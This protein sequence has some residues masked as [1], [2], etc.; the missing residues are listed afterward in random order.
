MTDFTKIDAIESEIRVVDEERG[1]LL[2]ALVLEKK[3]CAGQ[4]VAEWK[5]WGKG[6]PICLEGNQLEKVWRCIPGEDLTDKEED[7]LRKS[8]QMIGRSLR[9]KD[10]YPLPYLRVAYFASESTYTS[11]HLKCWNIVEVLERQDGILFRVHYTV[12]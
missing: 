6:L 10:D 3:L 11:W 5:S 1:K 7:A 2:A 4:M 8:M 12:V 9:A